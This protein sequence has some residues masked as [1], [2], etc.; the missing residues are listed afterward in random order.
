[1]FMPQ[2]LINSQFPLD[3][4]FTCLFRDPLVNTDGIHSVV[5]PP[6]TTNPAKCPYESSRHNRK[7]IYMKKIFN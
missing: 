6:D 2:K 3:I 1:M 7:E 4:P 5:H